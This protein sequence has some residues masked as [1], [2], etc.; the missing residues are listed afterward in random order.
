VSAERADGS[1]GGST[2][3]VQILLPLYDNAGAPLAR[4][5]FDAVRAELTERFGGLTAYSRAPAVG[6]W[7]DEDAPAGEAATVRDDVVVYEVMAD[8]LDAAWW[9]A[10]RTTLETRFRQ[11]EVLIRALAARRL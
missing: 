10:Y 4:A 8:A 6:L 7:K 1:T 9:R 5:L 3:L 2:H 11:D